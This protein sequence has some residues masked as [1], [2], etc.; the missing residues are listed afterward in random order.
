MKK[1]TFLIGFYLILLGLTVAKAQVN[2]SRYWY[3]GNNAGLD[4]FTSPPTVLTN[5]SMSAFE[6]TASISDA[7]GTLQ[8]YTNGNLVWD[9]TNTPMP[10]GN[11]LNGDGAA[12]QTA[13]V[14]PAPQ[15]TSKYYIFTVDTNGGP[16]GICYS[17]V[18]M[19]L[20]G[21]NGDITVKNTQLATP[22]TEKLTA[23]RHAN[24][25]DAWVIVHSWNSDQFMV[26]LVNAAGVS[27]SPV[28]STVGSSHSGIFSNS[29]GYMKA[30]PDAKKIALAIRGDKKLEI[31]DFD[32]VTGQ[33]SN[34]ISKT[35]SFQIYGVEFS[36]DS[37]LLYVTTMNNPGEIHQLNLTAGNSAAILASDQIIG[38]VNGF[39][40]GMQLGLDQ[41]IYIAQYQATSISTISF[42]NLSGTACGFSA[43]SLF[44]GGKTSM[45]GL[46]NFLQSFFIVADY[47]Y[48]DTC[49][50]APTNFT[51]IFAGP[52]SVKWNFGDPAS[53]ALNV[54][55][56]L[57][58]QHIFASGGNYNVQ[59][60]V[61]QSLLTDT[62]TYTIQIISTP[63]PNL[64]SDV[65]TCY[66][67]VIT[68][69]P[70][71]FTGA[72]FL[73][74]D[75]TAN[76]TLDIDTTGTY[77]VEVSDQNCIGR[78]T[79]N[80]VFNLVPVVDLGATQTGCEGD[81]VF[82]DAGNPGYTYQWQDGSTGQIY[83]ATNTGNYVV[84]VTNGP[85]ASNDNVFI[86]F[87]PVPAVGFGPD[88]TICK[89]FPM[90]LDA[91]NA[92]ATYVWQDGSTDPFLFA[93]DA[94][95]YAV[96]VTIGQCTSSDTIVIDQQDKP[97]IFLGEDS[98]LCAGQPLTLSGY[99]YGATYS[100][101]DGST[102]SIF[103]PAITGQYYVTAINQCGIAADSI[104]LTFNI[105]NCLVYIPNAFTP[106]HDNKNEVYNYEVNCTDFTGSLE[107]YNRFGQLLFKSENPDIGWDGT[108]EGKA[109]PEGAYIYVLKYT[110]YDNGIFADVK[111][112][113][114]F[115]LAR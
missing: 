31:F 39:L 94:G 59:L 13:I 7:A 95:T 32:N 17:E 60:I 40:G 49:S 16:R 19:T 25:V 38:T 72:A 88:T 11:G 104:N 97:Y 20:N 76:S 26:F 86:S 85:C 75:G 110:G 79:M 2:S 61:Y 100:W 15:N 45:Y 107:I 47:T 22:V 9:R 90:F 68:L 78:D 67:N 29:H 65:Q 30:S 42:P 37:K 4:F 92:N 35:Y 111:K 24:G 36:P 3:F 73:W 91:T 62:V 99:N 106:N 50:G 53:G 14:V 28:I 109:A 114:S 6:G 102:D 64:G 98:I 44:L 70:G 41:R 55:T 8:F 69:N 87:N 23:V 71:S 115:L 77:W 63:D 46:P 108:Y 105:C 83:P 1:F 33:V 5:S 52:D 81:T 43:N 34:V 112:R 96:I 101:Q 10:S 74:S 66:G 21:G 54:S 93:E 113:G 82:L 27:S 80:A 56:Q 48:A 57:N 89:G 103:S 58:P 84:T 51:T 18:D 12:T